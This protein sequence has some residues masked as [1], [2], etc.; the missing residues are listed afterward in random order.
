MLQ[1]KALCYRKEENKQT[2]TK[3]NNNNKKDP[4]HL[5]RVSQPILD[6]N[7]S[8][9]I[10]LMLGKQRKS[11]CPPASALHLLLTKMESGQVLIFLLL[12]D[13][14]HQSFYIT[15]E[16]ISNKNKGWR[17]QSPLARLTLCISETKETIKSTL[18][19]KHSNRVIRRAN[20]PRMGLWKN[21]MKFSL[22]GTEEGMP[23]Q[24]ITSVVCGWDEGRVNEAKRLS[25]D[26]DSAPG[27]M[28]E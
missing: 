22:P 13:C 26:R 12:S 8:P 24:S 6:Q 3:T 15:G 17:L 4:S 5:W 21:E 16:S 10:L 27:L 7:H 19:Y 23:Q 14:T 20:K 25:H 9:H 2:S 11:Y 18:A 1:F 28:C